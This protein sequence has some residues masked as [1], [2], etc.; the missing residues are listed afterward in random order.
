[1]KP[2]DLK[3]PFKW[4]ERCVLIKDRIWYV[5]DY[6]EHYDNFTFPGW[7]SP[8]VFGNSNPVKVEYCSGNGA[9]VAEKAAADPQSNWVAV[10]KRFI[11][12]RKI[13]SKIHNMH[14]NNLFS[15][16]GEAFNVTSRYFPPASVDEVYINFP[17]PWPKKRHAKHR[18]IQQRFLDEMVRILKPKGTITFVTD[19]PDY[20]ILTIQEFQQH[21]NFES[22]YPE[23]FFTTEF[24][25][26]G[27]SY[28]EELWRE[29]GKIIRYHRFRCK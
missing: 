11:R 26:Y 9:W 16:C 3:S 5:P 2:E 7:N 8:E 25:G 20:S 23:P 17:D 27:T 14:L 15:I 12:T 19:D 10:E 13:G 22:C 6:Y 18:I 29:K 4:D 1:M 28:F 24:P 21:P